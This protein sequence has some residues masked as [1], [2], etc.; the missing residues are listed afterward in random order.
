MMMRAGDRSRRRKERGDL[1]S[2]LDVTGGGVGFFLTPAEANSRAD[3]TE[4]RDRKNF[5]EKRRNR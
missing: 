2:R 4:E 1:N 5:Q 3:L